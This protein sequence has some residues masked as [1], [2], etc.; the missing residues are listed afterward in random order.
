ML[1]GNNYC[2]TTENV[3]G[4]ELIGLDAKVQQSTDP[5]KKAVKGRI[6][7]E[8]RNTLLLETAKGEKKLP[9]KEVTLTLSIGKEKVDVEGK[10]IIARPEDRVKLYWRKYR[11]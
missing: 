1:N 8:T 7:D 3:S 2:I 6:V 4:H 5:N 11:G 10:G 9:K